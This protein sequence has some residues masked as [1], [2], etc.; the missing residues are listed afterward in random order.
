VRGFPAQDEYGSATD[1]G[2]VVAEPG[3]E[4]LS[5]IIRSFESVGHEPE[6]LWR[7]RAKKDCRETEERDDFSRNR[8]HREK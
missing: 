1:F 8:P 2:A 6:F 3:E 5:V 7:K 4:S